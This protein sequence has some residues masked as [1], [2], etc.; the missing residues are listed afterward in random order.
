MSHESRSDECDIDFSSEIYFGIHQ[1]GNKFFLIYL[2]EN[3]LGCLPFVNRTRLFVR[4]TGKF[5]GATGRLK[6]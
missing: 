5:P 2:K 4:S 1:L 3:K 6:R